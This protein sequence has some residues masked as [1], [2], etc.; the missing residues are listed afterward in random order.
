[1]ARR[2]G[3][4]ITVGAGPVEVGVCCLEDSDQVVDGIVEGV[5]LSDVELS[6][7]HVVE[8]L[9]KLLELKYVVVNVVV[10]DG[11]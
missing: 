2:A 9:N 6:T 7:L 11:I 1:M 10:V 8:V 3:G 4:A 5:D